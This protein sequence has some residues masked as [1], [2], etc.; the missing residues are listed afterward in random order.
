MRHLNL[1]PL[2]AL[3][4][5]EA[6]GRLGSLTAAAAELGVTPGALSQRLRKAEEAIARPLFHRHPDGLTPTE[7]LADVLPRLTQ[8]MA[9]LDAAAGA[10]RGG[11]PGVLVLSVAPVFASR[12]LI[13]RLH[14][15]AERHPEITLRLEPSVTLVDLDASGVD[16]AI[17]VG[18]DA[19]PGV[20]ALKLMERRFFPVCAPALAAGIR[21]T[22]DL[23]RHPV[24]RGREDLA[25]WA[26]WLA[27][28]GRGTEGLQPGPAYGDA[29][30]CLDAAMTGQGLF[31]GWE[32]VA[33]DAVRRGTLA[34]PLPRRVPSGQAFW[35]VTSALSARKPAV[36]A[37]RDWLIAEIAAAE[38]D[39]A[40]L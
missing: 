15:F 20:P 23:Y 26:V 2:S 11:E 34:A 13:W 8:H 33:G 24:I 17:R 6:A 38:A 10:L 36:R 5:I 7:A 31:M 30:L 19:G 18:R 27:A 12:W 25:D 3:R 1:L 16:A 37:F 22:D 39:W 40:A 4:V 32:A 29:A 28:E 14:R 9:G 21:S 35:F